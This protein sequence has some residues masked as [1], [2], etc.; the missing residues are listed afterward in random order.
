[1]QGATVPEAVQSKLKEIERELKYEELVVLRK[2][3]MD[4][5]KKQRDLA[6]VRSPNFDIV[7]LDT[8]QSYM[9]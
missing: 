9:Y 6:E 4:R 5:V 1:M 8:L 3:A 7:S 2:V